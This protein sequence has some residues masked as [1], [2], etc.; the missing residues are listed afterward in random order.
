MLTHVKHIVN[1]EDTIV[2]KL[3]MMMASSILLLSHLINFVSDTDNQ[4]ACGGLYSL[5]MPCIY[6]TCSS[7]H[8]SR[9]LKPWKVLEGTV[10][11]QTPNY[12]VSNKTSVS[13]HKTIPLKPLVSV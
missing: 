6:K 5:Y 8:F 2:T 10:H 12:T 11:R 13:M 7:A 3:Q 9:V 1:T 4:I